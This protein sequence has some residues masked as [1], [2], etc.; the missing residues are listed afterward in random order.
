MVGGASLKAFSSYFAQL[1]LSYTFCVFTSLDQP[2]LIDII[3]FNIHK[4][5]GKSEEEYEQSEE[6]RQDLKLKVREL[7]KEQ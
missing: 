2:E 6:F 1:C 7:L 4:E 3:S 5:L